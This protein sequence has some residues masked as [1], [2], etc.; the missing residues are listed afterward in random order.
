MGNANNTDNFTACVGKNKLS[1]L[2][3]SCFVLQDLIFVGKY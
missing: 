2:V 3:L 1:D